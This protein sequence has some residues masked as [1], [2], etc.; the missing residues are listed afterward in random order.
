MTRTLTATLDADGG[1]VLPE[2]IRES[3]SLNPGDELIMEPDYE[4]G[5]IRMRKADSA[6]CDST[7]TGDKPG[8]GNLTGSR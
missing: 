5:L 2:S 4:R 7:N 8:A 3:L 1:F 6:S